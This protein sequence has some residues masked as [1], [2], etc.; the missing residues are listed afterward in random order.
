MKVLESPS[1]PS[2][3]K[4][5][6]TNILSLMSHRLQET[7]VRI[8]PDNS[9]GKCSIWAAIVI[10][11]V[12]IMFIIGCPGPENP[13]YV[14]CSVLGMETPITDAMDVN[15]VRGTLQIMGEIQVFAPKNG[16]NYSQ[17]PHISYRW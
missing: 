2:G 11:H 14:A 8:Y 17:V 12:C 10:R 3:T 16:P 15:S 6:S 5:F 13:H 1:G 9:D 7:R 4:R